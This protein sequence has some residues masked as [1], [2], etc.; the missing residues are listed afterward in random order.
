MANVDRGIRY[1]LFKVPLSSVL[2]ARAL[3]ETR[4]FLKGLVEV[5]G[6]RILGFTAFG[7]RAGE[8]MTAVEVAMVAG[9]PYTALRD[10]IL[11]HPTMTEGLFPLFSATPTQGE[12]RAS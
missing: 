11:T 2:R 7:A 1:R 12:A 4:G 10:A 8:V 3:G 9:L 5:D 6:E